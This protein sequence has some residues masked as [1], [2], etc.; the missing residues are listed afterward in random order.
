MLYPNFLHPPNL[1]A[2]QQKVTTLPSIILW[3]DEGCRPLSHDF[4]ANKEPA[5]YQNMHARGLLAF[6]TIMVMPV[7][8]APLIKK[9]LQIHNYQE[10][11]WGY[12]LLEVAYKSL[13]FSNI[14]VT[15]LS[16]ITFT[17]QISWLVSC[18]NIPK[19]YCNCN[20]ILHMKCYRMILIV[21]CKGN[22]LFD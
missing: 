17:Q 11:H 12:R 22:I 2:P 14:S 7:I 3:Q 15:I 10:C 18:R 5:Q 1:L 8:N 21:I 20:K 4:L 19:L 16:F 6:A 13:F 9:Q